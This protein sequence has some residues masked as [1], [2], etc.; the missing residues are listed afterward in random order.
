MDRKIVFT[1]LATLTLAAGSAPAAAQG[2]WY[3]DGWGYGSSTARPFVCPPRQRSTG[4]V[5]RGRNSGFYLVGS[6]YS[7]NDYP[8]S[9]E[10]RQQLGQN[11]PWR[12]PMR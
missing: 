10:N 1:G 6:R 12:G 4:S 3:G 11:L 7:T 8:F 5:S 9:Y 2:G